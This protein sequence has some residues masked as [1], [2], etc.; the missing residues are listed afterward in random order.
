MKDQ[1]TFRNEDLV[2]HV[3]QNYDP[4]TLDLS[5]Y[6]PFLDAL[7]GT[8]EY[9]SDAIREAIRYFLGGQY[10]NTRELA[11]QN[12]QSNQKL[13]EKYSSLNAFTNALQLPD[14][15]SCSIDH[16]TGTGKSYVMYG[17]A[18]ILLAE[19]AVDQVLV[20]CP[21]ITIETGLTEKF[22][23]LSSD[24]ILKDVLPEN[25]KILNPRIV[26]ATGTIEKGD[27]CIENIH[28]TR[29]NTKSAI[30]DSLTGKGSRTLVL[31]DEAHH[32]MNELDSDLKQWKGFLLDA[33]Y[34]FRYVVNVSGTCYIGNEYFADVIHRYSLRS[35]I[36]DRVVKTISY[37]DEDTSGGEDEKFQKIY[38]NHA[39]NKTTYRLVKPITILVTKDISTCKLLT[40][41]LI[42]FLAKKEGT[43]KEV[44]TGKVL[45]VTSADEHKKNV[46]LLRLVDD[47]TNPVEWIVSV[48]MLSEGWDVKNVF[49][50]VPHEERAF[51]SKLL[52]AQVLGRGLRIPNEYRSGAQPV[53]TVFNHEKW[54]SSIRHLVDEVMDNENRVHSYHV[55]KDINYDFEL[56]QVNYDRAITDTVTYPQEEEYKLLENK[57]I[58][59][60]TQSTSEN[61]MTGYLVA[62]PGANGIDWQKKTQTTIIEH[63]MVPIEDVA[64]DIYNRLLLFDQDT[65]T[66]YSE[67]WTR[68]KLVA[69]IRESLVVVGDT[70]GM[71]SKENRRRTLQAFGIIQR[72]KSTFPRITPITTE[73]FKVNTKELPPHSVPLSVLRTEGAVFLDDD[74]LRLSADSDAGLLQ[75]LLDDTDLPSRVTNK[76]AN[77]YNFKT[78]VN[79]SVADYKPE[80][81]F[82]S[83]LVKEENAKM[84]DAWI[85][86][87]NVGFY[88]IPFT[89]RKGEHPKQGSFNPDFFIKT[90]ND[91]LCVEIKVNDDLSDENKAKLFAARQHFD[92]LNGLGLGTT[93][94]FRFLSPASYELFFKALREKT[95]ATFKSKLE[96]DLEG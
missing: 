62:K 8:R 19:G 66:S 32:L 94:Y 49:Q 1:Q 23:S 81:E 63:E 89:W 10:L 50:I 40:K 70:S 28:A 21:S 71:I 80:Y 52:I 68:D 44:A 75:Q 47:K 43:P 13:Q 48:S 65:K 17:I 5:K 22:R 57:P 96:A 72:E 46:Q 7:C 77:T 26:N 24:R 9:Q 84:V 87:V 4:Q 3:S 82:M 60:S 88:A 69:K 53:V 56:D 92:T 59:Y 64:N 83:R 55:K 20:L 76:V 29:I 39:A 45:I 67:K 12:Y 25:A 16:A 38:A 78:P 33:K 74:S 15:L 51:N 95:Y 18:R 31:N 6:E 37:V 91:V 27:I 58:A 41:S 93:Y 85:K 11:T 86:S 2:L 36:E 73:P 79:V 42:E 30:E 14:C 35:A 61:A 54:S 34:G 90:G